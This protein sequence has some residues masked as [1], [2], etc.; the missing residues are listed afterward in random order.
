[1]LCSER[2]ANAELVMLGNNWDL[3][4]VMKVNCFCV[5]EFP[6]IGKL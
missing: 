1:V 3:A 6:S 5:A 2:I 4:F